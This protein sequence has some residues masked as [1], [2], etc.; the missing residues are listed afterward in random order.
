MQGKHPSLQNLA[1]QLF[2]AFGQLPWEADPCS[3]LQALIPPS[4]LLSRLYLPFLSHRKGL[5][6]KAAPLMKLEFSLKI[7]LKQETDCKLLRSPGQGLPP[8]SGPPCRSSVR[9]HHLPLA[10]ISSP[11]YPLHHETSL[12]VVTHH[13]PG[14]GGR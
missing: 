7:S 10:P 5:G 6:K 12:Q 9:C 3:C 4:F 8:C 13:S 14:H 11:H 2:F 1:L